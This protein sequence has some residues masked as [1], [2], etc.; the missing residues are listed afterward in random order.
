MIFTTK[1]EKK[2]M[3]NKFYYKNTFE[4]I[5]IIKTQIILL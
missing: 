4:L 1:V 5:F 3:G 2:C